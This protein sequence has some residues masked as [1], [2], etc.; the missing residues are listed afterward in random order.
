MSVVVLGLVVSSIL[1]YLHQRK[2]S[3]KVKTRVAKVPRIEMNN[4]QFRP[5]CMVR[6]RLHEM[7]AFQL[8]LKRISTRKGVVY[9][10]KV[11]HLTGI[12]NALKL[13]MYKSSFT[14]TSSVQYDR[15]Q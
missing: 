10:P 12:Q 9:P 2:R 13:I 3:C 4:I 14:G 15:G 5:F 7:L 8:H 6:W 11:F 1:Y